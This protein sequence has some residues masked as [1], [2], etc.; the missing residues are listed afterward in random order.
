MSCV[1]VFLV[2]QAGRQADGNPL[3]EADNSQKS[4][5]STMRQSSQRTT[6]DQINAERRPWKMHKHLTY[7]D[8]GEDSGNIRE[9]DE[10]NC[11][12]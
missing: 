3:I 7:K 4:R 5:F 2:F 1:F 8:R 12:S 9:K 10:R 11:S 6:S